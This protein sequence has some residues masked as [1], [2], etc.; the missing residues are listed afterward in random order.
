M[1]LSDT[2]IPLYAEHGVGNAGYTKRLT[3]AAGKVLTLVMGGDAPPP[4]A[5]SSVT[6]ATN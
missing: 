1:G 4:L 6:S 5:S 3:T 2:V